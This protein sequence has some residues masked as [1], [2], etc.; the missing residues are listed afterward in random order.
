MSGWAIFMWGCFF[1]FC[2]VIISILILWSNRETCNSK[3]ISCSSNQKIDTTKKCD[4]FSSFFR[5][6][7]EDQKKCCVT[8]TNTSESSEDSDDVNDNTTN[9]TTNGT[10]NGTTNEEEC[11]EK[12]CKNNGEWNS[13]NCSCECKFGFKGDTCEK[14]PEDTTIIQADGFTQDGGVIKSFSSV[15][16]DPKSKISSQKVKI[17]KDGLWK[18]PNI[19]YSATGELTSPNFIQQVDLNKE[20]YCQVHTAGGHGAHLTT[21]YESKYNIRFPEASLDTTMWMPK[22]YQGYHAF[23]KCDVCEKTS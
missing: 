9:G 6:T 11:I 3:K 4:K 7:S 18:I 16:Q 21:S 23:S 20:L 22:I 10:K 1:I 19:S 17:E 15:T 13:T 12:Q 8:N 14:C 5:C 2:I